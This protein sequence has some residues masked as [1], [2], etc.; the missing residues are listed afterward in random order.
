[1]NKFSLAILLIAILAILK[2]TL[3]GSAQSEAYLSEVT[4]PACPLC[5]LLVGKVKDVVHDYEGKI[6]DE[7]K[8]KVCGKLPQ[9]FRGVCNYFV[10]DYGKQVIDALLNKVEPKKVC[11]KIGLCDDATWFRK[12]V[13]DT[14]AYIIY[15]DLIKMGETN[16]NCALCKYV[17]SMVGDYVNKSRDEIEMQLL[18]AC[19]TL[20]PS[21]QQLCDTVV[22]LYGR[23]IIDYILA[24]E[25]PEKVCQQVKLCP[26]D[27]RKIVKPEDFIPEEFIHEGTVQCELCKYVIN[28]VQDY[29]R[30]NETEAQIKE[31]LQK[32]CDKFPPLKKQCVSFVETYEPLIIEF[33]LQKL[34]SGEICKKIGLCQEELVLDNDVSCP[35][36]K[37]VVG[38][39]ADYL[40]KNE[41]V[42]F[43]KEKVT[44]L[45]NYLP[46]EYSGMC[47]FV[48][49]Q[50]IVQIIQYLEHQIQPDVICQKIGLCPAQ[51]PFI[52][53]SLRSAE[54]QKN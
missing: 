7:F 48:A 43:I 3:A 11:S 51:E 9:S 30:S 33:L 19:K 47:K 22:L 45:C 16:D 27:D 1:M 36:C 13:T 24:F 39:V 52:G 23:Q 20:S 15:M 25:T 28:L 6:T 18:K 34:P 40:E 37:M 31:A 35:L 10:E 49:D 5:T 50:Y 12:Y 42:S 4:G 32:V 17:V 8:D 46:S 53:L 41:T 26:A 2:S 14:Q 38:A 44:A 21:L 29:I 54:M